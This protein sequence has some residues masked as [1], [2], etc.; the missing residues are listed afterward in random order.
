VVSILRGGLLG[1]VAALLV[2]GCAGTQA[3][4]PIVAAAASGSAVDAI[5]PPELVPTPRHDRRDQP[6]IRAPAKALVIG[7]PKDAAC[8]KIS[9]AP[10]DTAEHD[11]LAGRLKISVAKNLREVGDAATAE[12]ETRVVIDGG[13]I[14]MAVMAKETFQLDPDLYEAVGVGTLDVEAPK[15]L[16]ATFADAE[17]LEM[18]PVDLG[19]LRAYAARPKQPLAP[20]GK[21][22]AL[23]LALLV[24]Q[25]DGTLETISFHVR[26]VKGEHVRNA[27]GG[28][29]VGCTRVAERMAATIAKG[30]RELEREPGTRKLGDFE[31]RVPRD[32]VTA[33][34]RIYKLRPI[35]LYAGSITVS[36]VDDPEKLA[37]KDADASVDGK[38]LGDDVKWR[39][40]NHP[41]GGGWL[42]ATSG[43]TAVLI[44][45]NRQNDVLEEMRGVAETLHLAQRKPTP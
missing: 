36:T 19:G 5:G 8:G 25:P 27:T 13:T 30:T 11:L 29:L 33:G 1:L 21:D 32:Y 9:T 4:K 44:K 39:G 38:L 24:A 20:P 31:V 40:K 17:G 16:K 42:F 26:D 12:E 43:K 7:K 6:G 37:P 18:T 28:A 2:P 23:V 41:K 34:S 10:P 45:A 15:L 14:A 22:T 35:S 3:N